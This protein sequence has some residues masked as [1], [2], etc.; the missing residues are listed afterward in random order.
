MTPKRFF[1]LLIL[2]SVLWT[3][4]SIAVF[5][6]TFRTLPQPLL[7]YLIQTAPDRPPFVPQSAGKGLALLMTLA[8]LGLSVSTIVGVLLFRRWARV[9]YVVGTVLIMFAQIFA[10]PAILTGPASFCSSVGYFI[11]GV[12]VAIAFLPPVSALFAARPNPYEE[13]Q[14]VID[15]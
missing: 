1:R 11:Q 3:I 15:G 2:I 14:D 4:L 7:D 5:A 8:G 13:C 9:L 12:T 6:A 10:G